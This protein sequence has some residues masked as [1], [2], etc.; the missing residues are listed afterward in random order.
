M[1]LEK[2]LRDTERRCRMMVE[3]VKDHGIFMLDSEGR[4]ASWNRGAE[5]ILGYTETEVLGQPFARFFPPD[6]AGQSEAELTRA[7]T[8]GHAK[9]D[10]WHVRKDGGRFWCSGVV[11]ALRDDQGNSQ[12]FVAV[13][14]R[15]D[16]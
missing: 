11:T 4:V 3:S 15:P 7:L 2:Q 1:D 10:R 5:Q 12:G 14:R 6:M 9:D 8:Q 13:M 16:P